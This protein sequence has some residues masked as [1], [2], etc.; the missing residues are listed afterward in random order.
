MTRRLLCRLCLGVAAGG[1]CSVTTKSKGGS[2]GRSM[3]TRQWQ[4]HGGREGAEMSLPPSSSV[5]TVTQNIGERTAYV[6]DKAA[7]GLVFSLPC[8][9]F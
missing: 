9:P 3:A 5:F 1:A 6:Q 4:G 7:R 8:R 2:T